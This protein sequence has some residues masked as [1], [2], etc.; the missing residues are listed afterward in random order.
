MSLPSL[1]VFGPQTTW[2]T[3]DYLFQLRATLL[4]EP[5]LRELLSS[6]KGLPKLWEDLVHH[7]SRLVGTQGH[8]QLQSF[9]E[10]IDEGT[11][12]CTAQAPPNIITMPLTI[13]IH[14]VQ[15]FHYLENNPQDI[16]HAQL[17]EAAQTGGIQG[18]CIGL[19]SAIVVGCAKV[20]EDLGKLGGVALRLAACI[21]AYVDLDSALESET[22][23][24]AIRWNSSG[25]Q[26]LVTDILK[27]H[28]DVSS[29]NDSSNC[30]NILRSH[31]SQ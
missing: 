17:L 5:R 13:I 8:E 24:L 21:G 1:F 27:A 15:Y 4:L 6:I 3:S 16:T 29:T 14:L 18:F 11:L 28:H 20:E 9:Q 26:N 23:V 2:P 7:D 19:L 10:W 31:T 22:S 25:S 12:P 30:A